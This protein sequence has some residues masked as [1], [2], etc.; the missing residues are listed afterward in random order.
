MVTQ[1]ARVQTDVETVKADSDVI[2]QELET[3]RQ[4]N[5][6]VKTD[7]TSKIRS[8]HA[9]LK[10][11]VGQRVWLYNYASASRYRLDMSTFSG[12]LLHAD[13]SA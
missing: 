11:K 10:L 2:R 5:V 1:T 13:L 6:N 3:L 9:I 12:A 8:C 7:L 4:D